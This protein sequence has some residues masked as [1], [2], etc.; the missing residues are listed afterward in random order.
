MGR[1][2]SFLSM[3]YVCK[4]DIIIMGPGEGAGD[5]ATPAG[6]GSRGFPGEGGSGDD[7]D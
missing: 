1:Y 5:E 4:Y 3:V 7:D 6:P 2:F